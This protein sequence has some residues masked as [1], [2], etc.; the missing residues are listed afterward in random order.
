LATCAPWV[1]GVCTGTLQAH[2]C[3]LGLIPT[4]GCLRPDASCSSACGQAGWRSGATQTR[5]QLLQ[6]VQPLPLFS[7]IPGLPPV[8]GLHVHAD[9]AQCVRVLGLTLAALQ[10]FPDVTCGWNVLCVQVPCSWAESGGTF[11]LAWVEHADYQPWHCIPQ[12]R[13]DIVEVGRTPQSLLVSSE[14]GQEQ[15]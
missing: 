15:Q 11:R 13:C 2:R 10:S 9:D 4:A 8:L 12:A 1:A 7:T 6:E 5:Q 14:P 3:V